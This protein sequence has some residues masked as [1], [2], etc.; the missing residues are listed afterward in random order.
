MTTPS[1]ELTG[2]EAVREAVRQHLSAFWPDHSH[3][4][5]AWPVGPIEGNLPGFRVR[6][7][8]PLVPTDPWVYVTVGASGATAGDGLEFLILAPTE[9]DSHVETLAMVANFHADP[10]HTVSLG[11]TIEI[12]RPWT[13][14]AIADHLLVSLPYPYG[15]ALE[16]CEAPDRHIQVL[17]LAP[18]TAAEARYASERGL[19][20]LEQLLEQSA[21]DVISPG[22]PSVV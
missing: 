17:W 22:R 19:E 1:P 2:G 5:F 12:G 21:V 9:S 13:E 3:E 10:N 14:G 11:R 20:A 15:P 4:E 6:R 16:H 18:I 8:A 7:V